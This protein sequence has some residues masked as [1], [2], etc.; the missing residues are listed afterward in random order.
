MS[1]ANGAGARQ[2]RDGPAGRAAD[3]PSLLPVARS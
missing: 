1:F 2:T 3:V